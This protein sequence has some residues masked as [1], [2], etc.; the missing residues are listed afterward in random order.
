MKITI[1]IV[2]G[3]LEGH[4]VT[5]TQNTE[6]S[7]SRKGKLSFPWDRELG[8]PQARFL[9]DANDWTIEGVKSHHGTY[10]LN[11]QGPIDGKLQLEKKD[12]LKASDTWLFIVNIE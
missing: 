7:R 6:W 9:G 3:P 11:R 1:E 12:I 10:C 5:L 8:E 4:Q 2:S